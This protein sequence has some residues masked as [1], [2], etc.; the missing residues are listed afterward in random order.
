MKI[1]NI[2]QNTPEW[3]EVRRLKMT[4]S[5]AQAIGNAGKGL[6][7][8]IWELLAESECINF[9]SERYTNPHIERGHELEPLAR[10]MYELQT[11]QKV[12]QVGFVELDEHTGCSPDGLVGDNGMIEIKSQSN[13]VH[14]K[15]IKTKEIDSK[16]MWQMQMQMYVCDRQWCD[17]VSYNPNYKESLVIIRVPREDEMI[18]K[19][20]LG[21]KT[22]KNLINNIK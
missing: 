7:T 17:F 20:K 1:H 19:I 13:V 21:I 5:H 12:E 11:G 18:D 16:Y 22:G 9:D 8:Y 10:E 4:A 2:N 15:C 6:E 14:Y 3:L